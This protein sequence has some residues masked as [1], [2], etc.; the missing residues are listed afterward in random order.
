MEWT[1]ARWEDFYPLVWGWSKVVSRLKVPPALWEKWS[2][3]WLHLSSFSSLIC[4]WSTPW[5]V[6]LRHCT[7]W[8]L[9]PLFRHKVPW[10]DTFSLWNLVNHMH[11]WLPMRVSEGLR[12]DQ[13]PAVICQ[14]GPMGA[15]RV[16]SWENKQ[17]TR[18]ALVPGSSK[19][20]ANLLLE[21]PQ[22]LSCKA[23]ERTAGALK[24]KEAVWNSPY[25]HSRPGAW[26]KSYVRSGTDDQRQGDESA[27]VFHGYGQLVSNIS[28][29]CTVCLPRWT[30]WQQPC[31]PWAQSLL[32]DGLWNHDCVVWSM[33]NFSY[34]WR[35]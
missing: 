27:F 32:E 15:A 35:L 17:P 19:N 7:L 3:C 5:C 25:E 29:K 6:L 13:Q 8:M 10:S 33:L 16:H 26:S 24:Q 4:W 1:W 2:G 28:Y 22:E 11:W 21:Q 12:C 31:F 23:R 14:W 20:S 9:S 34:V 30:K 18:S